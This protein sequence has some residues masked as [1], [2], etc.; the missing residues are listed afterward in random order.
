MSISNLSINNVLMPTPSKDG[1]GITRK[2]SMAWKTS[3][4]VRWPLL[5]TSQAASILTALNSTSLTVQFADAAGSRRSYIMQLESSSFK[6]F[7]WPTWTA[8]VGATVCL[9]ES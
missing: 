9:I 6:Q 4:V 5:S 2:P 7:L 3:L 8:V 1:V